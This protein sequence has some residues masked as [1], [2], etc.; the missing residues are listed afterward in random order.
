M[1]PDIQAISLKIP[2]LLSQNA[3]GETM[4]SVTKA[5]QNTNW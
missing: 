2:I 3:M 5:V 1:K 4:K